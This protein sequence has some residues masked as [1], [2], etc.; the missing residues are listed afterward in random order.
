MG[1]QVSQS[2]QREIEK[3]Y[4][5]TVTRL[6]RNFDKNCKTIT[7]LDLDLLL[8]LDIGMSSETYLLGMAR[9]APIQTVLGGHPCTTG[10][11]EIDYF[12]SAKDS[13]SK[14]A[15]NNYSEHRFP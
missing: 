6:T 5:T 11:P 3:R 9:L 14:E 7:E 4:G 15:Q 10:L 8:Y 13:E 1:N 2:E 12:I